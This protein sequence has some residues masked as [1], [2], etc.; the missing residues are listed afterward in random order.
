MRVPDVYDDIPV[1]PM[2]FEQTLKRLEDIL[3]ALEDGRS[4]LDA[5]LR[6]FEEG[7]ELLRSASAELGT[8][9]T[10]VQMLIEKADGEFEL[11]ETDL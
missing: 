3:A 2:T 7:V 11:R 1:R 10:K 9:E 5:S 4:G 6:L 8:A